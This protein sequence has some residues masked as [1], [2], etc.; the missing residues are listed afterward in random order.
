MNATVNIKS[1]HALNIFANNLKMRQQEAARRYAGFDKSDPF[2]YNRAMS[3]AAFGLCST[4]TDTEGSKQVT[5]STMYDAD[6]FPVTRAPDER[7]APLQA[8]KAVKEV[9]GTQ[10]RNVVRP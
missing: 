1:L 8:L 3:H 2:A 5:K 4:R 10:Y 6:T 9:Q 7:W